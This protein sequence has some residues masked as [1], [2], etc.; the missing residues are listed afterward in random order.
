[1]QYFA[2]IG[3]TSL[4]ND[5]EAR[6]AERSRNSRQTTS[7]TLRTT[8]SLFLQFR[9]ENSGRDKN[10][11]R[12]IVTTF[13]NRSYLDNTTFV[14]IITRNV[15][16]GPGYDQSLADASGYENA[17]STSKVALS[18]YLAG[19]HIQRLLRASIRLA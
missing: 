13:R 9:C 15:S 17:V 2:R 3:F 19:Q 12:E 1:M 8:F 5:A 14:F 16:E 18:N 10:T 4:S 7:K 11:G 6:S